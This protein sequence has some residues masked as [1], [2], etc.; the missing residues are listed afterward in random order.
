VY[1]LAIPF[2]NSIRPLAFKSFP[3]PPLILRGTILFK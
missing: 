1:R 3:T 2:S